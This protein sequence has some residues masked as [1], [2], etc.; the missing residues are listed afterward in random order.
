[1]LPRRE[2][3]DA[4]LDRLYNARARQRLFRICADPVAFR[5]NLIIKAGNKERPFGE[6]IAPFQRA[7]FAAVDN[8]WRQVVGLP[9]VEGPV[10]RYSYWERGRGHSKTGDIAIQC[11]WALLAA[12]RKIRGVVAAASKEQARFLREAIDTLL[13]LNDWLKPYISAFQ[14]VVRN[15]STGSFL[16]IMATDEKT[17]MGETP[18]FVIVDE[19]T[20]WTNQ[21]FWNSIFS[22]VPKV[23]NSFLGIISNA[24]LAMGDSW[25]WT[26]REFFRTRERSYFSR[27]DGP[28]APW[29]TK[30]DLVDQ[31]MAMSQNAFDRLWNN[32][33]QLGSGEGLDHNDIAAA[34]TLA[35]PRD[36]RG[37]Y[38]GA[39][40]SLDLGIR[41][42]HAAVLVIGLDTVNGRSAVLAGRRWN[43]ADKL[44]CPDGVVP[45]AEVEEYIKWA[46][47]AFKADGLIYDEYQAAY[48]AQR[49]EIY[50]PLN[51]L[52][53]QKADYSP[54]GCTQ[55]AQGLLLAFRGKSVDLY[56]DK[57]LLADLRALKIVEKVQYSKLEA[58]R[59]SDGSHCDMGMAL[60]HAM[61]HIDEL[62]RT[63][64][65]VAA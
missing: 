10:Y 18:D 63:Y 61:P 11:L 17:S 64:A 26:A 2:H 36:D 30:E 8:S 62:L 12:R 33:W 7:D 39:I 14:N 19:F 38:H 6:V 25:Q 5:E 43:P 29:I 3:V 59:R 15:P 37:H 21:E 60:A 44:Q 50:N 32:N 35:G 53:L 65:P 58:P 31:R 24:G 51:P 28:V 16:K 47:K 41:K 27:L 45:I 52:T 23:Q 1:M 57:N 56:E 22:S 9:L 48:L 40:I 20:H 49:L 46:H 42:D 13:R 55:M 34:I 4:Y 54:K